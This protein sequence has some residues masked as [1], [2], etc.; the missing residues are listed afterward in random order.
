VAELAA[1]GKLLEEHRTKLLAMVERRIDPALRRRV[2]AEEVLQEAFLAA[3]GKWTRFHAAPSSM[4]PYAWL[5][6]IVLDTLFETWRKQS[7]ARRDPAR[8][9]PWPEQSSIQLGLG[10]LQS[11]TSPS[12]AF[13]RKELQD[14]MRHALEGLGPHDREILWMRHYDELSFPEAAAVLGITE[15]AATVRYVRALKRLRDLWLKLNGGAESAV[16]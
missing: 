4:T 2:E 9:M 14:R 11:G 1:L 6:R 3:Q 13:A 12:E 7:R 8:E 15:N 16:S 10:L 5:Y